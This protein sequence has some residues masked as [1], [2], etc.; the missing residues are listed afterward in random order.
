MINFAHKVYR[1]LD[2][3]KYEVTLKVFIGRGNNSNLIRAIMKK[4]FWF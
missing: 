3:A 2:I 1:E 4:R